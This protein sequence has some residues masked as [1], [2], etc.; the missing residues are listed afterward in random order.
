MKKQY[1]IIFSL[2]TFTAVAFI[3]IFNSVTGENNNANVP[4]STLVINQ[5]KS[6]FEEN[7]SNKNGFEG[8]VEIIEKRP[9]DTLM[10]VLIVKGNFVKLNKIREGVASDE[11]MIFNL[12]NNTITALQQNRKMYTVV[13]VKLFQNISDDSVKLIKT[14][15]TKEIS[16]LKCTQWRIKNFKDNTEITYWVAGKEFYFYNQLLKL[17]NKTDKCYKYFLS[18]PET[19]GSLPLQQ[20]ER[21]LLRDIKSSVFVNKVSYKQI[22]PKEFEIPNDYTLIS[23]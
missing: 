4:T 13:P 7:F 10:Y 23:N 18:F 22:D 15:N 12:E 6:M 17:W 19:T 5:N 14:K 11:S 21:T 2:V 1:L 20:V 8:I 16:G 3:L 9:Y